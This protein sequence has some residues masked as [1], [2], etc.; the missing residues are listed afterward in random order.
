MMSNT[1]SVAQGITRFYR[2]DARPC[3]IFHIESNTQILCMIL[4]TILHAPHGRMATMSSISTTEW[5]C[6]GKFAF[7]ECA[8]PATNMTSDGGMYLVC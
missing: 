4:H 1:V 8:S 7:G 6:G 2:P 5:G 3:V